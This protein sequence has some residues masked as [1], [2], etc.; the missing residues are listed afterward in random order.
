LGGAMFWSCVDG[1]WVLYYIPER[2]KLPSG[3]IFNMGS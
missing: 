1:V 3:Y 2:P